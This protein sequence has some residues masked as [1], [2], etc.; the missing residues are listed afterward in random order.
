VIKLANAI[1]LSV[2]AAQLTAVT[3]MHGTDPDIQ[4]LESP[5]GAGTQVECKR[6]GAV[7]YKHI[8]MPTSKSHLSLWIFYWDG[9]DA[10]R[11]LTLGSE[12]S[13][14]QYSGLPVSFTVHVTSAGEPNFVSI[15]RADG[16]VIDGLLL[17]PNGRLTPVPTSELPTPTPPAVK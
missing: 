7:I 6:N 8:E 1:R 5:H 12:T 10:V 14:Q 13:I 2:L 11:V 3:I 17:K 15:E 4:F 16:T 9:K